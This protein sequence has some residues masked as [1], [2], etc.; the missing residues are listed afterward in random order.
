MK[1]TTTTAATAAYKEKEIEVL[2]NLAAIRQAVNQFGKEQQHEP[3]NWGYAGTLSF[4]NEQL[5]GLLEALTH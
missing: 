5:A 4:I 3:K 2:K 1:T